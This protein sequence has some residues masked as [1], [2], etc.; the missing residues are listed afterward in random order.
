M[1]NPSVPTV[2][3]LG[4]IKEI[5]VRVI[6]RRPFTV[7]RQDTTV[8]KFI[9]IILRGS[10]LL[11][12]SNLENIIKRSIHIYEL[13]LQDPRLLPAGCATEIEIA[14]QLIAR[15]KSERSPLKS[16]AM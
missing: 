15:I 3:M 2:E 14:R 9:T 6:G 7:I 10:N 13:S 16:I 5:Y 4:L 12:I 8:G 11:A 1:I